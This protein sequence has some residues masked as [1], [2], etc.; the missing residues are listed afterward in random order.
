MLSG[1]DGFLSDTEDTVQALAKGKLDRRMG[2][3]YS[4]RLD[5]VARGLNVTLDTLT[6]IVSQLSQTESGIVTAI[7]SIEQ[8]A[9]S[10]SDRSAQQAASL[11]ETSSAMEELSVTTRANADRVGA[12]AQQAT[13]A[14]QIAEEGRGIVDRAIEAMHEIEAG[15][16]QISEIISVIDGIAFQTN[17]LALNAAVEA[18]RAGEAGK[19]FAVVA[20]EVR[21]LAQRSAEAARD[22]TRLIE[23]SAGKVHGGA[24]LVNESGEVLGRIMEAVAG[25]SDAL[26]EISHA[27]QEQSTAITE[28]TQSISSLD[29]VTQHT[30]KVASRGAAEAMTLSQQSRALGQQLDFFRANGS[31]VPEMAA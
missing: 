24:A 8:D 11:Q 12:S 13:D 22:I 5:D 29:D 31:G 20:S 25:V 26:G 2:L 1:I 23:T 18:A 10:L 21:T 15:S 19:G 16:S 7:G 6:Q 3:H 4:G 30:A 14:R 17:L 27:T 9:N 28:V